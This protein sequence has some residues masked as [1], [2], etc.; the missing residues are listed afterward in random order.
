M[1]DVGEVRLRPAGLEDAG[2]ID[3]GSVITVQVV[4][5]TGV[6]FGHR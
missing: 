4:V 5:V 6:A 1:H 2:D 3:R